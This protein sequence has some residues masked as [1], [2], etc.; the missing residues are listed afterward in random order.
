MH[1][2]EATTAAT[3]QPDRNHCRHIFTDGH[4]C[5]SPALRRRHFCYFHHAVHHPTID[6]RERNG[7]SSAFTL[8]RVEDRRS[9][10]AAINEVI[11]RLASNDLDCRRAG[12]ILYGLQTAMTTLPREVAVAPQPPYLLVEDT[13][14]DPA[15]GPLAPPAAFGSLAPP[16]EL[17]RFQAWLA[18]RRRNRSA[19]STAEVTPTHAWMHNSEQE[20]ALE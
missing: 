13:I 3:T 11:S 8:P 17:E 16:S 4:R 5:G 2:L 20:D 15:L 10:Q 7:R 12:Q 14:D 6:A 18:A 1:T 19:A 9:C